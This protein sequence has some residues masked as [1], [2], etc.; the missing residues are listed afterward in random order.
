MVI[1]DFLGGLGRCTT[2]LTRGSDDDRL[3]LSAVMERD[4]DVVLMDMQ[5]PEMDGEEATRAIRAMPPPR[6]NIPI[7]ALTADAMVEHRERYIAAGVNDLGICS[8][9]EARLCG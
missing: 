6:C 3:A 1:V 4:F 7:L 9:P 5:M 2:H 8:G